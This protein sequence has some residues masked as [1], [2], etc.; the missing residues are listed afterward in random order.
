MKKNITVTTGGKNCKI[1][2]SITKNVANFQVM[3]VFSPKL[4]DVRDWKLLK[5]IKTE[6]LKFESLLKDQY[7]A[8]Y[9]IIKDSSTN[10]YKT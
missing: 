2:F 1:E 3:P 6:K 8:I 7:E 10:P 9:N 5:N 4:P